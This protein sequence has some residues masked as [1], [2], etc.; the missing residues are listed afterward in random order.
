MACRICLEDSESGPLLSVC[1]CDGTCKHVHR[2]CLQKWIE[3]SQSTRCE[4]CLAEYTHDYVQPIRTVP[5]QPTQ[6][7]PH[8]QH[9]ERDCLIL[10]VSCI[11]CGMVHGCLLAM[12]V[13]R[14]Y[15]FKDNLVFGCL[16]FNVYHACVWIAIFKLKHHTELV[17]CLWILSVTIGGWATCFLLNSYNAQMDLSMYFNIVVTL[18][19]LVLSIPT[20]QKCFPIGC[21]SQLS[22]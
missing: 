16:V 1:N 14:G 17:S 12:D 5:E 11:W 9:R 4:L 15:Q 2:D 19:G 8:P 7:V 20:V 10:L 6:T 18:I 22:L 13:W 3:T 21:V